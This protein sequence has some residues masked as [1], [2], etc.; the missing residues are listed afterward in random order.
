MATDPER[1]LR[2]DAA[3]NVERIL[4]SAR[5]VFTESGPDAQLDEIAQHA[6]V[7]SR[8]LYRRFPNKAVLAKAALEQGIA[9]YIAPAI[10]QAL[11]DDDPLRALTS[12]IDAAMGLA[13]HEHNTLA[14]ARKAGAVISD[15]ISPYYTSLT[16]LTRRAQEAGRIRADLAPEDLPRIMAMLFSLLWTMDPASEGW[17]R[18][19]FLILDGMSPAAAT[20]LPEPVPLRP[21]SQPRNWP[22]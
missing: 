7:G 9:E 3:R 10:E 12:V 2:T 8:T 16:L 15:A 19:L 22:I 18:Y 5:K 21:S 13:A 1:L 11:L 14:A 20:P 17:R 6:G 4:R